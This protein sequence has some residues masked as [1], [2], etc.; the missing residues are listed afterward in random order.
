[1]NVAR[2]RVT[3][4]SPI[5]TLALVLA[6]A[7]CGTAGPVGSIPVPTSSPKPTAVATASPTVSPPVPAQSPLTLR[8][9]LY[10]GRFDLELEDMTVWVANADGT[11]AHQLVPGARLLSCVVPTTG[12]VVVTNATSSGR[13]VPGV[14]EGSTLHDMELREDSLNLGV[15]A[16]S[17]DGLEIVAEAW[18]E[19][20]PEQNG[21]YA[22]DLADPRNVRRVT[23]PPSGHH[24]IPGCYTGDGADIAF[25][26]FEGDRGGTLHVVHPDGSGERQV[27]RGTYDTGPGCLADRDAVVVEGGGK[28]FVVQLSDGSQTEITSSA[29]GYDAPKY[30]PWVAPDGTAIL[31]SM[32]LPGPYHDLYAMRLDGTGL[33]R[34]TQHPRADNE[35]PRLVL[36]GDRWQAEA[37]E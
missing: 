12:Q 2:T 17:P 37:S 29:A 30:G 26:R 14:V 21:L 16:C 35:S 1:M 19:A 28:L 7:A 22:V 3:L 15:A 31:F 23:K 8:G 32:K 34:L 25:L 33:T 11:D 4:A 10:F 6:L 5:R 20:D 24:D 18:D 13:I 36:L 9:T 27:G